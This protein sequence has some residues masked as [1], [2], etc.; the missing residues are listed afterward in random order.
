MTGTS[1]GGEAET[2]A[3]EPGWAVLHLFGSARPRTDPDAI[4]LA[5]KSCVADGHQV[6][7]A[8]MLGHR[9]DLGVLALG[10][11]PERLRVLQSELQR[12]GLAFSYSYVSMTE[13]SEYSAQLPAQARSARLRP[14]LPPEE[15]PAFCFYPM[16]KRRLDNDNWYALGFDARLQLMRSHGALGRS[17]AGR[18]VQLVTGS[19]GLD[20]YEWGVSLF[21]RSLEDLKDCVYTMRFDEASYRYAEFGPFL[22][23][24]IDTPR[25]VLSAIGL[26]G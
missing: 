13:L 17:F 26:R 23:G 22:S 8:A 19:T 9:A 1:Q 2:P 3:A 12:A 5:I 16:S 14:V 6:V 4:E 18:I 7:T 25:Q 21:G 24:M 10:P 20:D 15:M 11:S